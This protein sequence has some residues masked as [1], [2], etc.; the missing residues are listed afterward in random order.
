MQ[1]VESPDFVR[2]DNRPVVLA[3]GSFDGLHLGHQ[4]IIDTTIDI[5]NRKNLVSG[6]Y[7]FYP[8][9]LKVIKPDTAPPQLITEERKVEKLKCL[10]VDY[11]FQQHFTDEFSRISFHDFIKKILLDKINTG[12]VVVGEDFRFGHRA[13][14]KKQQLLEY[15]KKLDFEVSIMSAYEI[16]RKKV[17]SSLIRR[18]IQKGKV[19]EV[20]R[21]L[22]ENYSIKG[23]VIHGAGRGRKLGYP[24]ANLKLLTEYVLPL[25]GVYAGYTHFRNKKYRALAS[26]GYNPTFS[27]RQEYSIEIHVLDLSQNIY[28]REISFEFVEFLRPE[29]KFNEVQ[30]LKEQ[31]EKDILYTREILC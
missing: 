7:S 31:I 28:G 21:F 6:V 30:K 15:G 17:S 3:I 26:L 22:G 1:V 29:K 16:E 13:E 4:K 20:P 8:H 2:Q 11:Y 23:T 5:A 9:P 10:G 24:T 18:L 14:G 27:P 12:Y 19:E 25:P